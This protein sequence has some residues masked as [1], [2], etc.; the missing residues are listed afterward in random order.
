[1]ASDLMEEGARS[2]LGDIHE[3]VEPQATAAAANGTSGSWKQARK[4]SWGASREEDVNT[5]EGGGSLA[6]Y[7]GEPL[8]REEVM[9]SH[10]FESPSSG[11]QAIWPPFTRSR[12]SGSCSR[13]RSLVTN[14]FL[15]NRVKIG[16]NLV[17]SPINKLAPHFSRSIDL[18]TLHRTHEGVGLYRRCR[19]PRRHRP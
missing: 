18:W 1:M 14:R 13:V 10:R 5:R 6:G 12:D 15:R 16:L 2:T 19:F 11:G 4:N 9:C 8:L 7:E 17:S 3:D